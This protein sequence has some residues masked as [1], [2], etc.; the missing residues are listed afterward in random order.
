MTSRRGRR[1]SASRTAKRGSVVLAGVMNRGMHN[2][3]WLAQDRPEQFSRALQ[4]ARSLAKAGPYS[5]SQR[6][7]GE[8]GCL[9]QVGRRHPQC[10]HSVNE[11]PFKINLVVTPVI[12]LVSTGP[13]AVRVLRGSENGEPSARGLPQ[14]S[15]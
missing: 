7:V 14:G 13:L 3:G 10:V 8:N 9:N 4:K 12:P 5:E 6:G 15:A 1:R 2:Q 11:S